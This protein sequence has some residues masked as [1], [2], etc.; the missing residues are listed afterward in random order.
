MDSVIMNNPPAKTKLRNEREIK[1][2]SRKYVADKIGVSDY[3]VGQW[4]RGKHAPYPEHI[5]RL[6]DLF[7]VNAAALGLTEIPLDV[8]K[9]E[10]ESTGAPRPQEN[11]VAVVSPFS[12]NTMTAGQATL[13]PRGRRIRLSSPITV[14]VLTFALAVIV[15]FSVY[16]THSL[17]PAHIK[18][19]GAWIS[20][21]G[22]T[23]GDVIHFA[24]YAYPTHA[25]EPAIDHVNFTMY[26]QGVDPR[27][28]VV[29]C[30]VHTPIHN[31]IFACDVNLR[32]LGTPSGQIFV[33]FDVYD[34][35]GN[36]NLEPNGR[37]VFTYVPSS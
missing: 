22:S 31:H 34:R 2:W 9:E 13:L 1:G 7:G 23:V 28:W 25:G 29:A 11:V 19:G 14:T 36:V 10:Q 16:L 24:A 33:S 6:C 17:P 35:Q 30:V 4:E 26:W 12:F 37:H 20:P 21:A 15:G 8:K 18:P 27:T 32:M 5:Q 3:T